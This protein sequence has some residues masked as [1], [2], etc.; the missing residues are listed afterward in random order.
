GHDLDERERGVPAVVLVERRDAHQ[1]VDAVLRSQQAVS[2]RPSHYEGGALQARLLTARLVDDLGLETASLGPL[3]VHAH[4]HLDPVLRLHPTLADRD[5][6]DGVVVGVGVGEE[7]VELVRAQLVLD[8]RAL[9]L[10]LRLELRIA[11]GQL[12]QLAEVTGRRSRRSQVAIRARLSA[13]SR[14]I[15]PARLGSSQTPGW[16]SCAS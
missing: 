7:K 13:P 4:Q 1:A 8:R 15:W 6:D 3:E 10:D 9:L 11:L 14:A 5:G 16:M 12:V 2:P